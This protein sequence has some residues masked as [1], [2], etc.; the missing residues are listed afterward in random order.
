MNILHLTGGVLVALPVL[1]VTWLLAWCNGRAKAMVKA[2]L[3]TGLLG[4]AV[5]GCAIE[6]VP[7]LP[8]VPGEY[9]HG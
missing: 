1:L 3:I 2:A 8:P 9:E 6:V 5:V 7:Q 4:V